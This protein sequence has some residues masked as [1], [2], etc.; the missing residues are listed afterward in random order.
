MLLDGPQTDALARWGNPYTDDANWRAQNPADLAAR[1]RGSRVVY[2]AAGNGIASPQELQDDAGPGLGPQTAVEE[3]V[4]SMTAS[5]DRA[6]TAAGVPHVYRP[7]GGIHDARHWRED[8]AQFW[9]RVL[10]AWHR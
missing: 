4:G 8:L 1:L 3:Q 7:H 6:L 9:P 5:Y 2:I 10:R